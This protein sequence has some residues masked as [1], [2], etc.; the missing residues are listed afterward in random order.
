[1]PATAPTINTPRLTLR[2]PRMTDFPAYRDAC[3]SDRLR[4]MGG[5]MS[6]RDAWGMFCRDVAQWALLGH[7][8]WAIEDRA[9]GATVGQIMLSRHPDF[10]ETELGWM[11]FPEGESKGI[12]FEA[13][14]AARGWAY[15]EGAQ[16]TLVSYIHKDNARSIALAQRLGA[17]HDPGAPE[18]PY[19]DHL[20]YRHPAPGAASRRGAA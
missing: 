8:G 3:A 4:Y 1:M 14:E 10:A 18:C 5:P 20:V 15:S 12:A 13:A 7:G 17:A 11:V 9:T 16:T 2:A 6:M 19:P